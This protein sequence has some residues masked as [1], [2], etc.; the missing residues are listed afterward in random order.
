MSVGIC[1]L[2]LCMSRKGGGH[3]Y[4]CVELTVFFSTESTSFV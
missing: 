2:S 4:L 3:A 1:M